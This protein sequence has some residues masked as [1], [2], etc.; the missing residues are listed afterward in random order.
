MHFDLTSP[1]ET[2]ASPQSALDAFLHALRQVNNTVPIDLTRLR[3]INTDCNNWVI[4]G[5][6]MAGPYPGHDG[7]NFKTEQ[8]ALSNLQGI[9]ADGIDTFVCLG[10][11]VHSR[12]FNG[13]AGSFKSY[14]QIMQEASLAPVI[15]GRHIQYEYAEI[16]LHGV[17]SDKQLVQLM[18]TLLRHLGGGRRLFIHCDGGHGRTGLVVAALLLCLYSNMD[19]N[20][21]LYFTQLTHNNRRVQDERTR[22]HV[23]PVPSPDTSAQYSMVRRFASFMAFVRQLV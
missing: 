3:D 15:P 1:M 18:T 4:P 10:G 11:D 8:D 2:C 13:V 22:A 21:S 16:P 19:A 6:V 7:I 14:S 5:F 9:V 12:L 23:I 17:P 20:F